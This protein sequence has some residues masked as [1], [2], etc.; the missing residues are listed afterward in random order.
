VPGVRDENVPNREGLG[1]KPVSIQK[2]R[3]L[4]ASESGLFFYLGVTFQANVTSYWIV[5]C[6]E[7]E[8]N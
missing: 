7:D 5:F 1:K 3:I 8:N 4:A 6:D 2:G